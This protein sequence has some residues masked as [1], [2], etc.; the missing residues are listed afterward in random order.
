[1]LSDIEVNP[2]KQKELFELPAFSIAEREIYIKW[3]DEIRDIAMHLIYAVTPLTAWDTPTGTLAA[4]LHGNVGQAKDLALGLYLIVLP[5]GVPKIY[6][7][8]LACAFA[9]LCKLPN[10]LK[11]PLSSYKVILNKPSGHEIFAAKM[12]IKKYIN[13]NLQD[14]KIQKWA[15]QLINQ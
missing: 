13:E 2:E 7:N 9:H 4:T 8:S 1:M 5:E 15:N 6:K 14:A 10:N 12:F 3:V 11:I